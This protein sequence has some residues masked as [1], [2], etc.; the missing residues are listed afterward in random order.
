MLRDAFPG[1]AVHAYTATATPQVRRRHRRRAAACSDPRVLVGSFDRPNLI[2]RVRPRTDR[3]GQVLAAIERHRDQAGIVY[4]IR[5]SGG[6]RADGGP[7]A[8]RASS[9]LRYHAG[10]G[11]RRAPRQPGGVRQRAGRHRRRHRGVRHG[12]RPLQRAL[13]HPRR[14]AEVAR[15]LSAGGRPGRPRRPGGGVP[16]AGERRRLRPVEVDPDARRRRAAARRPAQ[17]RRDVR[18]LPAGRVPS[19]RAG[20]VL[21]PDATSASTAARATSA[22]ARRWPASDTSGWRTQVLAARRPSCAA[23]SAPR[24]SPTCWPAPRPARI[25]ELRHDRLPAYGGLRERHEGAGARAGSISSSAMAAWRA[26]TTSTRRVTLTRRR[27]AAVLRGEETAP[28]AHERP[29]R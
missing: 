5:R 14:H 19:P 29:A 1:V 28:A 21:R 25:R 7:R 17:A 4:C 27:G 6:R 13:R 8:P 23:A 10:P 24:T 18:V 2:Y 26:P 16:A 3:L 22:S 9:A 12:H 11:R 20:D 15:A